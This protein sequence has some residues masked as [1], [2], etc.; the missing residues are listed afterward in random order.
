VKAQNHC[1]SKITA[2]LPSLHGSFKS[3]SRSH[4]RAFAAEV[5]AGFALMRGVAVMGPL[6]PSHVHFFNEEAFL[7]QLQSYFRGELSIVT[8]TIGDDFAV[9][10]EKSGDFFQFI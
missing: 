8:P 9:L 4:L 1:F 10:R 3:E 5:L 7:C 2:L 6:L